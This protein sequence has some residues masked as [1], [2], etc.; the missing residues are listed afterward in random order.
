MRSKTSYFNATLYKKNL[1]RFWPLWAA[2]SFIG[3]L[4]PLAL[5]THLIRYGVK[6]LLGSNG[7][8]LSFTSVYYDVVAYVVPILAL[9]YAVLVALA[10]WSYLFQPRST[11][12]MHTLPLRREGVFLTNLL[13]GLTMM[14]IPY[15]VT[16]A[17]CVLITLVYGIFD[18]VGLLVT[19]LAVLGES[20]FYFASATVVAF[21]TGNLFALPVLYFIFHF[22]AVGMDALLSVLADGFIFGLS[23]SYYTGAVEF[24][25]P[26]V[27][28][29]QRVSVDHEY[30]ELF[31]PDAVNG[32]VT[33]DGVGYYESVLTS[34]TLENG[35]LI[36]VYAL[37]GVALLA[38]AFLLY[39]RRRSESAGDVVSVGWMKPV[40]RY[41]VALCGAMA[42]GMALYIVFWSSFQEGR[43]YEAVPLVCFMIVAGA[44]FYYAASMLLAK[45]L[46]VF[47]GSW[48][49]LT[50]VA[51]C[52]VAI[53][54]V[55]KL[56]LLGIESR[57][58]ETGKL[59]SLTVSVAQNRYVLT[60]EED[61]ELIGEV[62]AV[63][64]A[65][66]QDA[67]YII[68]MNENWIYGDEEA[69]GSI[70]RYNRINLTYVLSNG[71]E[72]RR[73]YT[74][75]I[76]RGRLTQEG[77]YDHAL[78]A[79]VNS[80]AMKARRFHL[81][82]G[83]VLEG[84]Y[85]YL[86]TWT[87]GGES[88][89]TRE[90]QTLHAAVRQDIAAGTAGVYDWF[91]SRYSEQYAMDLN[92]EF[93]QP[94]SDERG[95]VNY[96]YD[97]ISVAVYPEMTHTVNALL[98]LGLVKQPE[99]NTN[100]ELYPEQYEDEKVTVW[101]DDS[102]DYAYIAGAGTESA[103]GIIGGADSPTQVMVTCVTR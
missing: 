92:L 27:Y 55:L 12:L 4:F 18:P 7:N 67:D 74:L 86:D 62:R 6:D 30:R 79:L 36:A 91:D 8:A 70:S 2:P 15:A 98:D 57:V 72:V 68:D 5:L 83:Y 94:R 65:I 9:C 22:L 41:G 96:Y 56:D 102:G 19:I 52:A 87:N 60:P 95:G 43:Y 84:G 34:V 1:T 28:L 71:R 14:V 51:L 44:I 63:H 21:V 50:A 48:K 93:R 45:S 54:T 38:A 37:V 101:E 97:S 80:D 88:L 49:G 24:L 75:P 66:V 76:S 90:A 31:V 89:S 85:L 35:W 99:L 103:I 58:P 77:T 10:V 81:D 3:A 42:G 11:G 23:G 69:R 64:T 13:S 82:D 100:R 47:R 73:S 32:S 29:M 25:S 46:R 33:A 61:A 17:L 40:F 78:D 53:C 39:R 59:E 26:T 16:G 20:L